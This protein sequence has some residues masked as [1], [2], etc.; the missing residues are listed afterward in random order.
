VPNDPP[1]AAVTPGSGPRHV[2]FHPN[3]RWVYL[4]NEMGCT[5]TAFNWDSATGALAE[6]QTITTLPAD[7][8]GPSTCAEILVHPNGKFLYA[9]NRGHDSLAVFAIDPATGRLTPVEYAP[10]G[11]KWPRNFAFDPT[12]KWV[13]VTNHNSDNAVVLRVDADTGRLTQTGAPVPVPFPFCERFL[14]V[15]PADGGA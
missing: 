3:G 11:G 12:G 6:F 9:S 10:S 1:F 15:P 8:T 4:V 5:V 2:T 7:F 14:P 13:I